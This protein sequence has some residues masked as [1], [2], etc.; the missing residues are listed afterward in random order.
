MPKSYEVL[1]SKKIDG[2][3]ALFSQKIHAKAIC[4]YGIHPPKIKFVMNTQ[5][6]HAKTVYTFGICDPEGKRIYVTFSQKFRA[7]QRA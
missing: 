5:K 4:V 2:E 3:S 6:I 7:K 1:A